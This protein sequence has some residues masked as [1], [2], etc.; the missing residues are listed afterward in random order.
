MSHVPPAWIID[1][2]D[3]RRRRRDERERPRLEVPP[4]PPPVGSGEDEPDARAVIV[5]DSRGE[6]PVLG[7]TRYPAA[8]GRAD[9][10]PAGGDEGTWTRRSR[11]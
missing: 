11:P 5:L 10:T 9:T 4:P 7:A 1:E 8:P 2:A 6:R 3:T